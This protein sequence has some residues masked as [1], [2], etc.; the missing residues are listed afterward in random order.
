[1]RVVVADLESDGFLDQMTRVHCICAQIV[2]NGVKSQVFRYV[3]DEIG[4]ALALLS[5]AD[6]VVFHNG[7][8]FDLPAIEKIYEWELPETVKVRDTLVMSR[9]IKSNIKENDYRQYEGGLLEGKLIGTHK[10]D[11]WGQRMQMWKGDYA[12]VM[13]ER[14]RAQGISD[15]E[16][17]REFVW[18]TYNEEMGAY[19]EQD[20]IVTMKLF[21]ELSKIEWSDE[22][23][24]LEHRIHHIMFQQ[25]QFGF[26]F[27]S[28]KAQDLAR[29]LT[30]EV[31]ALNKE[32]VDHF[33][34]WY[35][36]KKKY[37][38]APR[39]HFGE[40]DSRKMWAEVT[41]PKRD[42][43]YQD[44]NRGTYTMDAPF[45]AI[46]IKDFNPNSRPQII[47]RLQTIY[48]W[49]PVDFTE[50]GNPEISDDVLRPLAASIPICGDLAELFF[51]TKLLGQLSTGKQAWLGAV[52]SD[53]RIHGYVNIGGTISGRASHLSPNIAQVPKVQVADVMSKEGGYNKKVIDKATGLPLADCF[54][55][56][57]DPKKKIILK[58]RRGK[59]GF[60]CRSLFTAPP[61][62]WLMGC[63]LSGI[64]LRCLGARLAEYD[65]GEYLKIILDGDPHSKNQI[66][67]QLDSRDNAKTCLYAIM[68][69]GGDLKVGSIVMPPSATADAMRVRGKQLKANLQSGIPAFGALIKNIGKQARKKFLIGLDGRK[70]WVRSAHAA[71][72]L[73]LQSDAALIA[74]LWVIFFYDAM[75]E[76]GYEWGRDWGLCAWVHDEIQAACRT[77]EIA[78]AAAIICKR[79]ARE[80]GEY[81][82]YAA[83]VAAESKI[84]FDW[85]STH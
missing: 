36:P 66:A 71:L 73:Q 64:E 14:A 46:E 38:L 7:V 19:C 60:E 69:G 23:M 56:N 45:C 18:G 63:D 20:V 3:E 51:L 61:G 15:P 59:F 84:G 24:R 12:K 42:V 83:P 79:C 1:M 58:G 8:S 80:A 16:G 44:V 62:W 39:E 40:D 74:K 67:F 6:M 82:N 77:K 2:E 41:I 50:K 11:A 52:K 76:A 47:D 29:E 75:L 5:S 49:E 43:K 32:C 72:N 81:F 28:E 17:I 78:E 4:D 30:V 34:R 10:L 37:K 33:G 9:M 70:L 35:A 48:D 21:E 55:P 68:Y 31:E 25:E 65:Q 54:L 27:D 26:Q 53:Q 57:G 13:E 22:A 85:A